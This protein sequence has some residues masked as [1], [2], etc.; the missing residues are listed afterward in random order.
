MESEAEGGTDH[1]VD[2]CLC[3]LGGRGALVTP[4]LAAPFSTCFVFSV[5]TGLVDWPAD[6]LTQPA[7]GRGEALLTTLVLGTAG[8]PAHSPAWHT[9]GTKKI[10]L[11]PWLG[12]QLVRALSWY[13]KVRGSITGQGN[14]NQ[15]MNA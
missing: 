10:L 5:S 15:P 14:K 2:L 7:P 9:A 13:V 11:E 8:S 12:S 1:H 4:W 6:C 3:L